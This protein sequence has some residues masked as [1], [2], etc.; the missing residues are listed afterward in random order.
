MHACEAVSCAYESHQKIGY[1]HFYT[2]WLQVALYPGRVGG[3][4]RPGIDCLGMR[5]TDSQGIRKLSVKSIRIRPI[6]ICNT[7]ASNAIW[8]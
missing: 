1:S 2:S 7:M 3:E 5:D 4:K 8:D 6:G